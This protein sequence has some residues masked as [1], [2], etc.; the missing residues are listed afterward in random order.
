MK[1]AAATKYLLTAYFLLGLFVFTTIA[2]TKPSFTGTW[3]LNPQ[4][5]KLG[6]VNS[7]SIIIE[8]DQ[9][10]NDL[11]ESFHHGPATVEARYSIDGKEGQAQLSGG[12]GM[13]ATASWEGDALVIDWRG[14]EPGR[15][16]IRKVTLA[17]DGKSI[18][19]NLKHSL[20]GDGMGEETWTLEKQ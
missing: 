3:K 15:Y 8:F 20:P 11:T 6:G 18:T 19:V 10:D 4:K 7:D 9:K 13:K 2:Q 5:S 14:P 16:T 12:P 17:A 1:I